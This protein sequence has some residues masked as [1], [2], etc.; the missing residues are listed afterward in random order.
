MS[1]GSLRIAPARTRLGRFA[2]AAAAMAGYQVRRGL[3]VSA[4][5]LEQAAEKSWEIAPGVDER[6]VPI[7]IPESHFSR[8]LLSSP[9]SQPVAEL[10][11]AI[12][13]ACVPASRRTLVSAARLLRPLPRRPVFDA[14]LARGLASEHG[15]NRSQRARLDLLGGALV[16][17]FPA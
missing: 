11:A 13:N 5:V 4:G 7:Y 17:P 15:R 12:R 14:R 9:P 16:R 6:H 8:I 3:G 10:I 2:G 1:E